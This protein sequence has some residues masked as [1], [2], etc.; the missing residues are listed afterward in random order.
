MTSMKTVRFEI[1]TNRLS[2]DKF[3]ILS[4]SALKLI[5]I[6]TMLIDHTALLLAPEI[7]LMTVPFFTVGSQAITLHY[8]MRKIGRLAF[9]IF[10]FLITEGFSHTRNQKRYA[11][12]LL[13]FAI[14]SEIP[15]NVMK[16]GLVFNIET[17]NIFFTL[18]LGVLMLYV[19][20]NVRS[21]KAPLLLAIALVATFLKCD[22]GLFGVLLVLLIYVLKGRPA[23]QAILAYPLL[24]G[25]VAALAAFIPINMYNGERGFIKSK[26]MKYAFYVFYPLHITILVVIKLLMY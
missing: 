7:P 9:P 19:L 10:C 20:E 21:A 17:Q 23:V 6:I 5:A 14:I 16:S 18:F 13:I 26:A 12:S 8:V 22:Y 2:F 24:S 25:G 4:G 15:F 3:K 11:F 1:M